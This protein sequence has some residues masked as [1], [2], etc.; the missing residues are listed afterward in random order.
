MLTH[1]FFVHTIP[2]PEDVLVASMNR[3]GRDR[4]L[5]MTFLEAP[6]SPPKPSRK[7]ITPEW[8]CS[9]CTWTNYMT[10]AKGDAGKSASIA[11]TRPMASAALKPAVASACPL[12]KGGG[13]SNQSH[14]FG[15]R[16]CSS[17]RRRSASR[18]DCQRATSDGRGQESGFKRA[19]LDRAR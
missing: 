5:A 2:G 11:G 10:R 7:T 16:S 13:R 1:S 4:D 15:S 6:L 9:G 8:T 17:H 14:S 12:G 3:W 19:Y 18:S